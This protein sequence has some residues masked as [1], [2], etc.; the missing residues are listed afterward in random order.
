MGGSRTA[1]E[2]ALGLMLRESE[3]VDQEENEDLTAADPEQSADHPGEQA[4]DQ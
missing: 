1:R 2:V 4:C 3:Q